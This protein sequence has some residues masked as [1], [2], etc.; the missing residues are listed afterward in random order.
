MSRLRHGV[1]AAAALIGSLGIVSLA[2]GT[3]HALSCTGSGCNGKS[4]TTY[5]CAADA[6]TVTSMTYDDH[7]SGGTYGTMVVSLRYSH[8]CNASWSRVVISAGGTAHVTSARAYMQGYKTTT[9]RYRYS[10]GTVFSNM[11]SGSAVGACGTG[12]FNNGAV[13]VTRCATAG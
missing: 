7:A 1:I 12:N 6:T 13:V 3:A 5:G 10:G 9:S 11:R 2:P 4:P 8:H